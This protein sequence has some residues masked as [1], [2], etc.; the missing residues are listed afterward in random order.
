ME[1]IKNPYIWNRC[2]EWHNCSPSEK[3]DFAKNCGHCDCS[4]KPCCGQKE[5]L[6]LKKVIRRNRRAFKFTKNFKEFNA[7]E[8]QAFD[9]RDYPCDKR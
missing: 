2:G 3:E 8:E 1:K 7:E 6:R 4:A 5:H 9:E